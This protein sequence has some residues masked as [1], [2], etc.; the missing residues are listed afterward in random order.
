MLQSKTQQIS[1]QDFIKLIQFRNFKSFTLLEPYEQSDEKTLLDHLR[2]NKSQKS[3][4]IVGVS[5]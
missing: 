2:R 5:S 3:S 1:K 4:I